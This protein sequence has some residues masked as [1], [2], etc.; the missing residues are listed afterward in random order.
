MNPSASTLDDMDRPLSAKL[1]I[2]IDIVTLATVVFGGGVMWQK[3]ETM[4]GVVNELQVR[5][6]Q[7][8]PGAA[9]RLARIEALLLDVRE[10]Q[11]E[12]KRRLERLEQQGR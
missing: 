8:T 2:G 5:S 10:D 1:L 12:I 3:V 4:A 9:E 11:S 7:V 6:M